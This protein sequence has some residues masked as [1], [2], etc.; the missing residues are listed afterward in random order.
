MTPGSWTTLFDLSAR[1]ARRP[2]TAL[3]KI[4]RGSIGAAV[5]CVVRAHEVNQH[6]QREGHLAGYA[7]VKDVL[8][9]SVDARS[10]GSD[11]NRVVGAPEVR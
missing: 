4:V 5:K 9:I 8:N 11:R 2:A 3:L 1:S 10:V 7:R 6:R